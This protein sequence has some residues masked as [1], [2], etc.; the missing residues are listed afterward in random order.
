MNCT[1]FPYL[2]GKLNEMMVLRELSEV[3][4][5]STNVLPIIEPVKSNSNTRLSIAKFQE[6]GMPFL[7]LC[8]PFRGDFA[9]G[10]SIDDLIQQTEL[11]EYDNWIPTFGVTDETT[12][13][14]LQI[15]LER[16]ESQPKAVA[17]LGHPSRQMVLDA[18][19]LEDRTIVHHVFIKD[20]MPGSFV[21]QIEPQRR[22]LISDPFEK[23]ARNAD[24]PRNEFFSDK[25][26]VEANPEAIDFG[27]F[28]IVGD[29]FSETG[30]PAYAITLHHIH[31]REDQGA[32][33]VDHFIS[34]DVDTPFDPSGKTIQAL[35]K[36]V[37]ALRNTIPNDTN[38]CSEYQSI[39]DSG[40]TRG[41]GYMKR[42]AIKHHLEV[43]LRL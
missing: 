25:H 32:L 28:S 20:P 30:G 3:I 23:Q 12:V 18:L 31:N 34:D 2:R 36:L 10:L 39:Y 42:L 9:R 7:M 26:T 11:E 38:A 22:V 16:F 13:G 4:A 17:Y 29:H 5:S 14:A 37:D 41:L 6:A 8:N 15:F 43:M 1:Y 19:D 33:Y 21:N 27:D 35:G 24:Y 40:N